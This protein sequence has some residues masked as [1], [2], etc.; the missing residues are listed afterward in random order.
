MMRDSAALIAFSHLRWNFVYQR[1]QHLLSRIAR[2]RPV[3]FIEEPVHDP[4]SPP[5]WEKTN[6]DRNLLVFRPHTPISIPGFS[7]AHMPHLRRLL[8]ELLR[9]E[10][11]Q[12]HDACF[13]PPMALP[14]LD[15]LSPRL[16]AL[17]SF[18]G[19]SP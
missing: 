5:H 7:S 10:K 4:D 9:D 14:L 16:A 19:L 6:P 12:R 3:W 13:Y 18:D 17:A 2:T 15:E 1:P 8:R 11:I